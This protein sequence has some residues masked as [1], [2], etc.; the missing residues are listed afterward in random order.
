MDRDRKKYLNELERVHRRIKGLFRELE[1]II[2]AGKV[3]DITS[4]RRGLNSL[5]AELVA[6]VR[7]E[8]EVFYRDLREGAVRKAQ[9]ALIPALDLFMDSMN[10][11]SGRAVH[12]FERYGDDREILADT[13]GFV[14]MLKG[15]REDILRR[16]ESE[17]GSL[18]YIYRAYFFDKP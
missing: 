1:P 12:F 10:E 11:V 2:E 18:F 4:L 16:I 8:D 5:E 9:E 3:E 7:S 14:L 13:A 15:L 17:E 6:H